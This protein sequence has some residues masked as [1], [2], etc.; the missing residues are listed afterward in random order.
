MIGPLPPSFS[1][2][3][4]SSWLTTFFPAAA[5]NSRTEIGNRFDRI[6][7]LAHSVPFIQ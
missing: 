3:G 2:R 1:N 7:L 4:K 5:E 6:K